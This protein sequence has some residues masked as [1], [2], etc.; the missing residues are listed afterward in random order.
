MTQFY[1][2]CKQITGWE[3]E[4][5]GNPGYAVKYPDGYIFWSPKEVFEAV[6]LPQGND[7]TKVTQ[8]MVDDM[9]VEFET[10]DFDEKTTIVKA[11]LKSGFTII[12]HSSCVDPSNYD[13]SIGE[14][15]CLERI[16]NRIWNLLGFALQWSKDGLTWQ[17]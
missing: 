4:N 8:Q 16:K 11:T 2:G 6:Y 9:I 14:L 15:I 10:S 3:Q 17:S 1:I 13:R 5:D 7:P 12:E